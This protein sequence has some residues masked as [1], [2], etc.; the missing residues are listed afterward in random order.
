MSKHVVA[1]FS[2]SAV[3][4]LGSTTVAFAYCPPCTDTTLKY[5]V[6]PH[7]PNSHCEANLLEELQNLQGVLHFEVGGKDFLVGSPANIQ[8]MPNNK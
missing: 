4:G 7:T 8:A 3:A 5:C 1:V 6:E 2:L